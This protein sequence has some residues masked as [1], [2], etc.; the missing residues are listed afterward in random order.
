MNERMKKAEGRVG[1]LPV[2]REESLCVPMMIR[3]SNCLGTTE[4][5]RSVN[6]NLGNA[7]WAYMGCIGRDTGPDE[8]E[9]EAKHWQSSG[10]STGCAC[11]E[12]GPCVHV[13]A[14]AYGTIRIAC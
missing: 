6:Q 12:S 9:A 13:C 14:T 1:L 10:S 7:G 2:P 5:R 4:L 11:P 8:K 3:T